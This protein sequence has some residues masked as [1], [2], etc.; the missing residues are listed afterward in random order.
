MPNL[1]VTDFDGTIT[2]NDVYSLVIDRYLP[3]N[4]PAIWDA[5][6][7]GRLT[8][9][10]AMARYMAY[11]PTAPAAIDEL[12]Q[13]TEPDPALAASV[14]RLRAAG[15]DVVIVSA[16]SSW[17]IERI[18]TSAGVQV[19]V[20][21]N[22][23]HLEPNRGLVLELPRESPFFHPEIGVDK[24]AVVRDALA[25]YHRVAYAGDG[26]PDL[27]PSLLVEGQLRFARG[28]LAREL[29]QKNLPFQ[30]YLRWSDIVPALLAV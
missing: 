24:S 3:P 5:Y 26:P 19:P 23:G 29:K 20:H 8:H 2:Q 11:F 18:L 1:L 27:A 14:E 10:E 17:Y 30:P 28:W 22:P 21:S 7:A 6:T 15:W 4:A 12:L 13:A 16:G 25:R 9:F